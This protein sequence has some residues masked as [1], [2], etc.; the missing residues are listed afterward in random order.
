M[1]IK[2]KLI[3]PA[4][5]S[6]LV[7]RQ[8]L[9]DV[10]YRNLDRKL[11]LVTAA[12]GFGKTS[13]LVDFAR[14]VELSVCWLALD[15]DDRDP[16]QFL[17]DLAASIAQRFPGIGSLTRAAMGNG[18]PAEDA[19]A[20]LVNEVVDQ[21]DE[22]FI[23][24]LD[25]YHLVDQPAV[26]RL[27]DRLLRF[28]PPQ[29]R[30]ILSGRT[31][32]AIDLITLAA[33]QDVGVVIPQELCFSA[34]E[35]ATLL[36]QNHNLT[37][38]TA[39]A[40]ALTQQMQGWATGIVLAT[41][42][43]TRH[44]V[45]Q[46]RPA[47]GSLDTIYVY[48]T[49]EVLAMQ[50]PHVRDFL[51]QTAVLRWMTVEMCDALLH[52]SD[53]AVVFATLEAQHLFIERVE[54]AAGV[55]FRYHPLFRE[56]LLEQLEAWDPGRPEALQRLAARLYAQQGELE[57][58]IRFFLQVGQSRDAAPLM[59]EVAP[60]LYRAGRHGW[61]LE[62]HQALASLADNAP[63]LQM[64]ASWI[65]ADRGDYAQA[66]DIMDRLQNNPAGISLLPTVQVDQGFIWY[67]QGRPEQALAVLEPLLVS[68]PGGNTEA[69]ALRVAGLCYYQ[70]G[71]G[72][73]ARDYLLRSLALYR[74]A[75]DDLF[76]SR[77][78]LDLV[79]VLFPQGHTQ[80]ALAY[81]ERGL[82]ILRGK[83]NPNSL[84]MP[85]NNSAYVHH[86]MGDLQA[87]GR[88]Y[89]DA[90]E[91]ARQSGQKP[92]EALV[93]IGQGDLRRDAGLLEKAL[94]V[95]QQAWE[96]AAKIEDR[97]LG[98]QARIGLATCHRLMGD[99]SQALVWIDRV[100]EPAG[101]DLCARIWLERGAIMLELGRADEALS[102]LEKSR[103]WVSGQRTNPE[104]AIAE[105]WLAEAH[106]RRGA[107]WVALQALERALSVG[108]EGG[109]GDHRFALEARQHPAVLAL[110][111]RQQV[112]PPAL[113]L[114][115]QRIRLLEK[116][117]AIFARQITE[118]TTSAALQVF[119]LGAG[120]VLLDGV[121]LAQ[122]D[123]KRAIARLLFLYVIDR[124]QVP[125]SELFAVFWPSTAENRAIPRLHV[126][127]HAAR[128]V[129]GVDLLQYLPEE[130]IYRIGDSHA[131]WYDVAEFEAAVAQANK[132]P[133]GRRRVELLKQAA[134]LYS[135]P[136]LAEDHEEWVLARRRE[137]EGHYLSAMISLGD[138]YSAAR[139]YDETE[140]WYRRA[141]AADPYREDVHRRL[142][143]ALASGG[144]KAEALRQYEECTL[145]LRRDLEAEPD[146]RTRDLAEQ[147]RAL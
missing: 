31:L 107:D 16:A 66:L 116:S 54:D 146:P 145:I 5:R 32:P 9:L 93:L 106:R 96:L 111:E 15:E 2:T 80:E 67:R 52:R 122:A 4:R 64:R 102:L 33:R 87:A 132:L 10:L 24:I 88:L 43:L 119:A 69:Y 62:W 83:G 59:D 136:Y 60:E 19:V 12:A 125:R 20:V 76:E 74:A 29:M 86:M 37:I 63:N 49:R 89:R 51:M 133:P 25:D 85:L 138:Y 94:D 13:L 90:L 117:S 130:T 113:A 53:A 3:V 6:G 147:I 56:F 71:N 47:G 128:Q 7:R 42:Q 92:G 39:D 118:E 68:R 124:P 34:D 14:E 110:A 140:H 101:A 123:W 27:L 23:L 48:L 73:R 70:Q 134:D 78:L 61:L 41:Q 44:L 129:I 99:L 75:G 97:R 11:T 142:M 103:D 109:Q 38:L 112:N 131:I 1:S 104:L 18:T 22:L 100:D 84:V 135:G 40:E 108:E 105:L 95:Y 120:R 143:K 139:D 137:L 91:A 58:A 144:R 115:R 126:S 127:M 121:E 141:L 98:N 28:L 82:D 79:F 30:L 55:R 65:L 21:V 81:Q 17:S 77:V 36:E 114:L 35:T 57:E 26:N 8:R 45:I 46:P 50:P 72:V